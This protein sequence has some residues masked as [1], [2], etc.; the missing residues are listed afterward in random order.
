MMRRWL[1]TSHRWRIFLVAWLL[2]SVH[3]ATNV[4]REHYP[5]FSL[6]EDGTFRVNR[7]VGFHP[8]IFVHTDG[9]AYINNQVFVSMLAAV[10]LF[11]FDPVLDALETY[12]QDQQ[13]E[14]G[15]PDA[16][17]R[18]DKPLRREFF[19]RV[20]A[21][22]LDLRFGAATVV[23]SAFFMAPLTALLLVGFFDVLRRRGLDAA[24]A[25]GLTLLLGFGT[26]LFFRA[27]TLNHNMFVMFGVFA[28]FVLLWNQR[29]EPLPVAWWRRCL[30]GACAGAAVASDYSAVALVPVLVGYLVLSRIEAGWPRALR[31]AA[32]MAL[33]S[34]PPLAFLLYSQWAMFGNPFLPA[35]Y[36]MEVG[37]P[38]VEQGLRGFS[39]PA[40]DLLWQNLFH[41]GFGLFVWAPLLALAFVPV[42]RTANGDRAILPAR[43]RRFV[44]AACLSLLLFS[45]ANQFARLQWNS[46]F[47]YLVPLVPLLMLALADVWR[48]LPGPARWSIAIPVVLHAWVLTVFRETAGRSWQLFFD[49]GLQLPWLRVL[50]MTSPPGGALAS[51][52]LPAVLLLATAAAAWL[53]WTAGPTL[54]R[55]EAGA[56][57]GRAGDV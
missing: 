13:V 9:Q 22:G 25:A 41:P 57:T 53:I 49:E 47:R 31:E 21:A 12:R 43:E 55:R 17:Y 42:G 1:P 33:G 44:Y 39:W 40:P 36:W 3:F 45:S 46:G 8:D 29:D 14:R 26:P 20:T 51:A 34:L 2:Y 48:R 52:W 38:Y 19:D 23:T 35:Q 5:A 10:P 24:D 27:S 18:T 15:V 30:A 37:N 4:V 16:E 6:A 54:R 11:V 56:V 7:Y 50:R 28:A 32:P